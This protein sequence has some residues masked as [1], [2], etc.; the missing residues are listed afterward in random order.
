MKKNAPTAKRLASGSKDTKNPNDITRKRMKQRQR[1]KPSRRGVS[2]QARDSKRLR[3]RR[4]P[5]RLV[6]LLIKDQPRLGRRLVMTSIQ[7]VYLRP[8]PIQSPFQQEL[9]FTSAASVTAPFT[10][11]VSKRTHRYCRS[12]RVKVAAAKRLKVAAAKQAP[13]ANTLRKRT[14]EQETQKQ[15]S[16]TAMKQLPCQGCQRIFGSAQGLAS[17]LTDSYCCPSF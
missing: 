7:R 3:V 11:A 15:D 17:H 8:H 12:K 6:L 14:S 16:G 5:L 9:I 2:A 4:K 1:F 10:C 13:Q